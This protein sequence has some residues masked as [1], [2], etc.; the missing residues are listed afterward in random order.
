M[1]VCELCGNERVSTKKTRTSTTIIDCCI[2]CSDSLGLSTINE[3]KYDTK[4]IT[5]PLISRSSNYLIGTE[6]EELIP[7]FH[8]K[9]RKEREIRG[10]DIKQ[11]AEKTNEKVNMIQKIENGYRVTDATIKKLA[12][13]LDINLFSPIVPQNERIIKSKEMKRMTMAD[14]NISNNDTVSKQKNTKIKKR[15]LGV[16]RVGGRKRKK[17]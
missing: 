2:K 7:N 6:T 9:I 12:K 16:S 8:I 1:G 11:L 3:K 15:R 14:A 4:N 17:D 10:W 5:K 13:V